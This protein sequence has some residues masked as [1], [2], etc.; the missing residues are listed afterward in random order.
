MSDGIAITSET[1]SLPEK[2]NA[3]DKGN[4]TD[5]KAYNSKWRQ[6]VMHCVVTRDCLT[7]QI[8]PKVQLALK[9]RQLC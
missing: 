9:V 8:S 3:L 6:F 7:K 1:S 4:R 2:Q 5:A